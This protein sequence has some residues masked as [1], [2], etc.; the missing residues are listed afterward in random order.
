MVLSVPRSSDEIHWAWDGEASYQAWVT[1]ADTAWQDGPLNAQTGPVTHPACTSDAPT[2]VNCCLCCCCQAA[3]EAVVPHGRGRLCSACFPH[4]TQCECVMWENPYCTGHLPVSTVAYGPGSGD[5]TGGDF[6]GFAV[7][8]SWGNHYLWTA[9]PEGS[10]GLLPV[11]PLLCQSH[12]CCKKQWLFFLRQ[13]ILAV[14][15]LNL[16]I[17]NILFFPLSK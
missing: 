11:Y 16:E 2:D 15:K 7:T 6:W 4:G 14:L 1:V 9:S 17:Y 8:R 10:L 5:G 3:E 13:P 12:F